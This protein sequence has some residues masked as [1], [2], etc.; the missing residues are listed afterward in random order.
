MPVPLAWPLALALRGA[1]AGAAGAAR[2]AVGLPRQPGLRRGPEVR[3]RTRRRR[4]CSCPLTVADAGISA[5]DDGVAEVAVAFSSNPQVSRPDIVVAARRQ[6]HAL[7]RPRRARS[8]AAAPARLRR[9]D[10]RRPSARRLNAASGGADHARAARAQPVGDRRAPAR[11]RRRRVRRRQ[12][13]RRHGRATARGPRIVIGFM[14]FAENETLAYLY[15]E[16][17]RAA[18]FRVRVRSVG[19]LRPEAVRALRR[20]KIDLYPAYDGSLLRYLVG[21]SP[22]AADRA[23]AA[24]PRSRASAREPMRLSRAQDR[25]VFVMK[26]DT[27]ARLGIAQAL[28][29]R[30]VLADCRFVTRAGARARALPRAARG[31]RAASAT[32]RRPGSCAARRRS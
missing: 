12:R 2:G 10:A 21:T 14:D 26:T 20:D 29:P 1:C 32:A 5:L 13:A 8:C 28:R 11:G 9:A 3:I 25:N 6:P 7:P 24:P 15:A 19:G 17:L 23:R 22:D 4:R 16:A 30:A 18:G 31:D 27:A